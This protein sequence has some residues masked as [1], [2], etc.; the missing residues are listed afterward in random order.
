MASCLSLTTKRSAEFAC[1]NFIFD[2][3]DDRPPEPGASE[4]IG[5]TITVVIGRMLSK[6]AVV[7]K[8]AEGFLR[9]RVPQTSL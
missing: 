9:R 6:A 8:C 2:R 4:V 5:R 7:L 1:N 3:W